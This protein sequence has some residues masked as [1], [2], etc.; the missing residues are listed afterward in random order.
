[1]GTPLDGPISTAE[2]DRLL[3]IGVRFGGAEY[4]KGFGVG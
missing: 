1:M 2:T 3:M 4:E